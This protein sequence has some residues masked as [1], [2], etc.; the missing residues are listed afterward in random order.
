MGSLRPADGYY[1]KFAQL[2][3][4]DTNHEIDNRGRVI[5]DSLDRNILESLQNELHEHNAYVR[6]FKSFASNTEVGNQAL[7]LRA[8]TL[9]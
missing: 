3:I 4:H 7:L 1:P 5:S 2:Y 6:T 9:R 8:D